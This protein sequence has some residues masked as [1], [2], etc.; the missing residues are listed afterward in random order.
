MSDATKH[1]Q[2]KAPVAL[3]PMLAILEVA[4]VMGY[5]ATKYG[6]HNWRTGMGWLRLVNACFRHLIAWVSGE[7]KDPETGLS[8]LAHAAANILMLLDYELLNLGKDDRWTRP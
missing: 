1:D 6:E 3:V 4:K 2:A 5:G 8:H 7:H